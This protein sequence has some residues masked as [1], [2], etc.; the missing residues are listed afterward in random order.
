MQQ[1]NLAIPPL[2]LLVTPKL[3]NPFY[4]EQKII[5]ATAFPKGT[6]EIFQVLVLASR[7]YR[8]PCPTTTAVAGEPQVTSPQR[9]VY[10]ISLQR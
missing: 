10:L 5:L 7:E 4:T 9:A 6:P 8:S 3:S 1:F 2:S